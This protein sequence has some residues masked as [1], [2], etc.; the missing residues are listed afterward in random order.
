MNPQSLLLRQVHPNFLPE[1]QL[2]SQA[3]IPF[4]KD[5]GGLSVYDGELI[6]V[7]DSFLHYT[8]TLGL[9]SAGVWG[10]SNKEVVA[11]GLT[12]QSDPLPDSP[13]H[14]LI[15]FA[16]TPEKEWRKLEKMLRA[17]ALA[18]GCLHPSS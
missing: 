9:A 7:N 14:A 3:F 17:C 11:T 13:A 15:N 4:P 10:V 2:S 5:R 1:G 6:S 12:S 18:H 8:E 16:N